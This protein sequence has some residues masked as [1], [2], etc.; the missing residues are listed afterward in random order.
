MNPNKIRGYAN[1][2]KGAINSDI[3]GSEITIDITTAKSIHSILMALASRPAAPVDEGDMVLVNLDR[4]LEIQ[5]DT[6]RLREALEWVERSAGLEEPFVIRDYA[7]A[8]LT[9]PANNRSA[10]EIKK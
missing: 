3:T 10:V 8:A 6:K 2:L 7:R 4:L 9:D 5:A 1:N